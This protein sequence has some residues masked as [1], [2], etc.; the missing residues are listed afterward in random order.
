MGKMKGLTIDKT[1][2]D[3]ILDS[4][5]HM[6]GMAE[7][8]KDLYYCFLCNTTKDKQLDGAHPDPYDENGFIC[9]ICHNHREMLKKEEHDAWDYYD[10]TLVV[11]Q[12]EKDDPF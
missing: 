1:N 8:M 12:E 2:H 10:R 4:F 3:D 9:D 6:S 5:T 7:S 11:N